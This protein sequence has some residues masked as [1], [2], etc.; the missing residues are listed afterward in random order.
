VFNQYGYVVV[1]NYKKAIEWYQKS[2]MKNY[3]P[4]QYNL[5]TMYDQGLGVEKDLKK[6]LFG[7][8]LV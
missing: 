3:A 7:G 4:A 6:A 5:G 2:A 8:G 1:K